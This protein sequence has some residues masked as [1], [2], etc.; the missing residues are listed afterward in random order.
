MECWLS[1]HYVCKGYRL[2]EEKLLLWDWSKS[3]TQS[4][5]GKLRD[6]VPGV[7]LRLS[8][9]WVYPLGRLCS[10]T[11]HLLLH[12]LPREQ[13]HR[14]NWVCFDHLSWKWLQYDST[15]ALIWAII[16]AWQG[17]QIQNFLDQV[18]C[19]PFKALQVVPWTW[20]LDGSWIQTGSASGC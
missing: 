4:F 19:W 8:F 14:W 6:L 7:L 18:L 17:K 16:G 11:L 2:R 15:W 13:S 20:L 5:R 1:G 12:R 10:W 3:A 9:V